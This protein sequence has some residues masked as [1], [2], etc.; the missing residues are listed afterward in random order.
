MTSKLCGRCN[1]TKSVN[2]FK[3]MT[4][5]RDGL[6]SYF[7]VC[8]VEVNQIWNENNRDRLNDRKRNRYDNNPQCQISRKIHDRLNKIIRRGSYSLRT[9]EI[10]GISKG[11]YL[12]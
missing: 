9:E 2:D 6:Q 1:V 8:S 7:K 12:D 5:A 4:A 3:K 10:L 11:L